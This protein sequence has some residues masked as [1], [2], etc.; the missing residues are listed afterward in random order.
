MGRSEAVN[1][2]YDMDREA[3]VA[4]YGTVRDF[5]PFVDAFR[6]GYVLKN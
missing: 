1:L 5:R 3:V 2:V 4:V 6:R